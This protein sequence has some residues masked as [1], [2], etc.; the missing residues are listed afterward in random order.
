MEAT[1]SGGGLVQFLINIIALFAAGAIFFL[2]IDKIAPDAFFAKIAKIAIGC[3]LLIAF[4][5]T[6]AAILGVGGAGVAISPVGIVWF[7]IA[8]IVAVVVLYVVNL[9]V[10]WLAANMGLAPMAEII[11]YVLGAVVLIALLVASANLLFGY[12]IGKVLSH[13]QANQIRLSNHGGS[14][15]GAFDPG[16]LWIHD[17]SVG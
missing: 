6:I 11:K 8:V 5:V 17:R 12:N 13:G 3:L 9:I 16:F 15:I 1:M 4:I 7:A 2:S 10:D 14:D